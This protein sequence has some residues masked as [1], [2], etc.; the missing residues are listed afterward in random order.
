MFGI[1]QWTF[2]TLSD[3]RTHTPCPSTSHR[4]HFFEKKI[5][6]PNMVR[7]ILYLCPF[8][9][10]ATTLTSCCRQKIK[11]YCSYSATVYN[12]LQTRV[13]WHSGGLLLITAPGCLDTLQP[14]TELDRRWQSLIGREISCLGLHHISLIWTEERHWAVAKMNGEERKIKTRSIIITSSLWRRR[15]HWGQRT[16]RGYQ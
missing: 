4:M 2:S 3:P 14:D 13:T 12:S 15:G 8:W 16:R 5:A 9:T 7:I 10:C 11:S 1:G 6:L